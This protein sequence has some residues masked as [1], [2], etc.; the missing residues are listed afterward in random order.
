M[1]FVGSCVVLLWL[2]AA[3]APAQ[4]LSFDEIVKNVDASIAP[5]TVKPGDSVTWKLTL[6]IADGWHTYP[7]KQPDPN[8]SAFVTKITMP[9][10]AGLSFSGEFKEPKA[11]I[12]KD[13]D[14]DISMLEGIVTFETKIK[15]AADAK[16]GKHKLQV[17]VKVQVCSK[18]TCLPPKTVTVV[19]EIIV[20]E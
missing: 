2:A 20:Q 1:R 8:Q 11:I 12:K 6:D 10:V 17:P 4:N 19:A 9:K 16:P 13:A 3:V 18:D 15:V 14:G 7:T 5:K